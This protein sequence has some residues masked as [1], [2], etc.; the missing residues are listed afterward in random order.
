MTNRAKV[1]IELV[2]ERNSGGNVEL[3]D[4]VVRNVVQILDQRPMD[5]RVAGIINETGLL[6]LEAPSPL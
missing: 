6:T 3:R 4:L 5:V 2:D 1:L